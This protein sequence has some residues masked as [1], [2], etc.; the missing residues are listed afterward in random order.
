ME[1][2]FGTCLEGVEDLVREFTEKYAGKCKLN[3]EKLEALREYCTLVD[4][5]AAE[6]EGDCEG[7]SIY[8]KS[9]ENIIVV[10]R[11]ADSLILRRGASSAFFRLL[12]GLSQFSIK[13]DDDHYHTFL[14]LMFKGVWDP[15]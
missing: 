3:E 1:E 11:Y 4:E 6:S 14:G 5:L 12:P 9:G 2:E 13:G 8:T 15:V 7:L 10:L